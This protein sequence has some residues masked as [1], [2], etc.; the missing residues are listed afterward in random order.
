M[1]YIF[2]ETQQP[3]SVNH[4]MS[5]LEQ[6]SYD[7]KLRNSAPESKQASLPCY[8]YTLVHVP[9]WFPTI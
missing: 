1:L 7:Q 5:Q 4:Q 2:N 8:D 6:Q 3:Y 9:V